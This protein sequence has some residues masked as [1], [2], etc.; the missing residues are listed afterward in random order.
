MK[1][2]LGFRDSQEDDILETGIAEYREVEAPVRSLV[3]IRLSGHGLLTYY[4]H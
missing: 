1:S 4:S 3:R 2:I